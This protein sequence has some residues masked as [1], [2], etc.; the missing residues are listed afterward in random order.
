MKARLSET[1]DDRLVEGN[2][3]WPTDAHNTYFRD[4]RVL[5]A[6][7]CYSPSARRWFP[8]LYSVGNHER[9]GFYRRHFAHL[10]Q[11][12]D[13]ANYSMEDIVN[14]VTFVVNYSSAQISGLRQAISDWYVARKTADVG[15][16]NVTPNQVSQWTAEAIQIGEK[17]ASGCAFHFIE[18]VRR[19][20]VRHLSTQTERERFAMLVNTMRNAKSHASIESMAK[21]TIDEFPVSENWIKW[22]TRPA[23]QNV[24]FKELNGSAE[25]CVATTTNAVESS[26]WLLI[27]SCGGKRFGPVEGVMRLIDFARMTDRIESH[28]TDGYVRSSTYHE[29]GNVRAH[30]KEIKSRNRVPSSYVSDANMPEPSISFAAPAHLSKGPATPPL[31]ESTK[32]PPSTSNRSRQ[33]PKNRSRQG[34]GPT[35]QS[36]ASKK[37]STRVDYPHKCKIP[38][39]PSDE[40]SSSKSSDDVGLTPSINCNSSEAIPPTDRSIKLHQTSNS[41]SKGSPPRSDF[42]GPSR[43]VPVFPMAGLGRKHRIPRK[44]LAFLF[45]EPESQSEA[46]RTCTSVFDIPLSMVASK[47][48]LAPSKSARKVEIATSKPAWTSTSLE[49]TSDKLPEDSRSA[50]RVKFAPPKTSMSTSLGSTIVQL[51]ADFWLRSGEDEPVVIIQGPWSDNSCW[52]DSTL[53]ALLLVANG[54][55]PWLQCL[56]IL[57]THTAYVIPPLGDEMVLRLRPR[58]LALELWDA[59]C[60][61]TALARKFDMKPAANAIEAYTQLRERM[62]STVVGMSKERGSHFTTPFKR[63][64]YSSPVTWLETLHSFTVDHPVLPSAVTL[65]GPDRTLVELHLQ[66]AGYCTAC[67][68]IQIE[69]SPRRQFVVDWPLLISSL[70]LPSHSLETLSDVLASIVGQP[71]KLYTE[72]KN[73]GRRHHKRNCPGGSYVQFVSITSLPHV[74]VIN[75]N[76]IYPEHPLAPAEL[77]FGVSDQMPEMVWRLRSG[78]YNINNSHFVTNATVGYGQEAACYHFDTIKG[79]LARPARPIGDRNAGRLVSVLFYELEEE[80]LNFLQA[81]N[82]MLT[83]QWHEMWS[84]YHEPSDPTDIGIKVSSLPLKGT[85]EEGQGVWKMEDASAFFHEC[86]IV[87]VGNAKKADQ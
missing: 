60:E 8:I 18:Q 25:R 61:Y 65:N 81:F 77:R 84:L 16:L 58:Y 1:I 72:A 13:D 31:S 74:I 44:R 32:L 3:G 12:L 62:I 85:L 78:V 11:I 79:S 47:S 17:A 75:I 15:H 46:K 50:P 49:R 2:S 48:G 20:G 4:N 26:H 69:V 64:S 53:I 5:L 34:N 52:I 57:N 42:S 71:L 35:A 68:C 45:S 51:H 21:R 28:A 73:S 76:N 67:N 87:S 66:R 59:I 55:E 70:H 22:W 38:D 23:I 40:H 43:R 39:P 33:Q 56:D 10:F 41:K 54:L 37:G 27:H 14:G 36:M 30:I 29:Q 24:V 19:F 9:S 86:E 7:V 80:S 63:G 83:R 6:T 82:L